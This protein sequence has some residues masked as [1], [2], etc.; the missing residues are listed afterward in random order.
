MLVLA[1]APKYSEFSES[2][3]KNKK[4]RN[5]LPAKKKMKI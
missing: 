4:L 5:Q 3:N 2:G 1:Q